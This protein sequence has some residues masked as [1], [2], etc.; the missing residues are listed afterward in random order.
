VKEGYDVTAVF[1]S[2]NTYTVQI[3]KT[4]NEVGEALA[5]K[6]AVI[7]N[8]KDRLGIS[9]VSGKVKSWRYNSIAT[10]WELIQEA[11]DSAYT[12]GYS[13]FQAYDESAF[14]GVPELDNFTAGGTFLSAAYWKETKETSPA[15]SAEVAVVPPIAPSPP[16]FGLDIVSNAAEGKG[17]SLR[18][19]SKFVGLSEK[20]EVQLRSDT[21]LLAS[22][23]ITHKMEVGELWGL[24]LANG[25]LIAWRKEGAG[26]WTATVEAV[27]AKYTEGF[28]G[29]RTNV[30]SSDGF[31]LKNFAFGKMTAPVLPENEALSLGSVNVASGQYLLV[32]LEK[33][34]F[35]INASGEA[36][37]I[38]GALTEGKRWSIVQAAEGTRVVQGPVYLSNGTDTPLYWTGAAKGTEAKTWT[39]KA[40]GEFV[41]VPKAK[42]LVYMANRVWASGVSTDESAVRFSGFAVVAGEGEKADPTSWPKENI[43]WF[44]KDD[45]QPV[46]GMGIAGPYVMVFK[47]HKT[48][49][50]Y[51]LNE[52]ENRRISD[53]VGCISHRSIVETPQGTFFLTPDQGVFVTNG[54][55]VKEASRNV[56]PMLQGLDKNAAR[57]AKLD[58][59]ENAAAGY[60]NGHYYLSYMAQD[61]TMKT[62]DY[63]TVLQSW[64]LLDIAGNQWVAWE[65]TTGT[66]AL[67]T[68]PHKAK[69]G[70]VKAFVEGIYQDSGSNYPGANSMTAFW[71]GPWEPFWQYFLRHR[72]NQP[73]PKKRI[74]ELFV[75]GSGELITYVFKQFG[76]TSETLKGIVD[77]ADNAEPVSP[78]KLGTSE[79]ESQA[80]RYWSLGVSRVWSFG[81]G[82]ASAEPFEVDEFS[83]HLNFRKS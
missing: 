34:L 36:T 72:F 46:T 33:K 76:K 47:R 5:E 20:V 55:S 69:G 2:P 25:R 26:F 49:T 18:V 63:D 58:E 3:K 57:A 8:P 28:P 50:I 12:K 22:T 30:Q 13:G 1:T 74:R 19:Y 6:A 73:N 38:K 59:L 67:Y 53:S 16:Y 64:W 60:L 23:T 79:K 81:F 27:D 75:D 82:N 78:V 29:I 71:T 7:I 68:I 11:A 10:K 51:D 9:V 54:S 15:I 24:S 45:G 31:R 65:P 44:E 32:S 35:S 41:E 62:L 61:G 43:V 37:E 4:V 83:V 42:Y 39:S 80:V 17:Y 77:N 56:R 40:E 66:T 70:V 52:G 21:G 14:T 48:W